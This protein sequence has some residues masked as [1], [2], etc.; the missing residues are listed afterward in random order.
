MT[1]T[2]TPSSCND[3]A[4]GGNDT[5]ISGA[6]ATNT[7]YGD[8]YEMHDNTRGG[9]DTLIAAGG[10]SVNTPP[11]L[12]G[13]ANAMYDNARGGNDMLIGGANTTNTLYGD[14]FAMHDHAR[15]ATTICLARW[16][17]ETASTATPDHGWRQ[18][19]RQRHADWRRRFDQTTSMATPF[20]CLATPTA[21]T[22]R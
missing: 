1:S 5:L 9:N 2:A 18:P 4:R 6:N 8:A 20:P 13:D 14:A 21:A 11:G 19:R 7:L 22:T 3:N 17:D 10:P 15:A 16:L 12:Y